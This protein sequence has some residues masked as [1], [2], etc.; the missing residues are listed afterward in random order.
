MIIDRI[1]LSPCELPN[2]LAP[3]A[4]RSAVSRPLQGDGASGLVGYGECLCLR[5]AMQKS[6]FAAIS[7]AIAPLFLGKSVE[8]RERLN[9][10][11]RLRLAS[12]GRSGTMLNALA[13]VDMALWDIAG[14]AAGRSL[15]R[16]AG[17]C[18]ADERAGDGEP[19]PLQRRGQ[20][21]ARIARGAGGPRSPRSRSHEFDLDVIEAARKVVGPQ[22]LRRRLQQRPH[23]GRY[24]GQ[25]GAL[26][27]A[28]PP[29]AGRSRC[30]R[31][32]PCSSSRR[33][34]GIT[35]GLGA[36]LGSAEQ[37]AVYARAPVGVAA[38]RH[39][40]DRRR[41]GNRRAVALLGRGVSIAPHT[42]FIGPAGLATL[43][44]LA[45][46]KE[47]AYYAIIE[48]RRTWTCTGQRPHALAARAQRAD[49]S[50][51]RLRPDPGFLER[52]RR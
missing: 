2:R 33:S 9:V 30:G 48:A 12:F 29:V 31:R 34:Q 25:P 32:K 36:D 37:L 14:K 8:Q 16:L 38:A 49:R 15:S 44:F 27:G 11:A 19:R 17:R 46:M 20:G 24:P 35:V 43:H 51:P 45:T 47:P 4:G 21:T 26:A 7:D 5:P 41:L 42:P 39:L 50:R 18:S 3:A 10:E 13:A 28:R 22:C 1:A 23:P 40:H 52:Y 6:L